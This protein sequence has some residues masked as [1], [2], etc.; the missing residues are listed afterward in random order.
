[1]ADAETQKIVMC[2]DMFVRVKR[3]MQNSDGKAKAL[4]SGN[5]FW[6]RDQPCHNLEIRIRCEFYPEPAVFIARII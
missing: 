1:V 6:I 3:Q 4:K 2:N 5:M